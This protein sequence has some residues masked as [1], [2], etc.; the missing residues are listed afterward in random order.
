MCGKTAVAF[1]GQPRVAQRCV[2]TLSHLSTEAWECSAC[3][4]HTARS[5]RC[6]KQVQAKKPLFGPINIGIK[7]SCYKSSKW[8]NVCGDRV[9]SKYPLE[10]DLETLIPVGVFSLCFLKPFNCLFG[11]CLCSFSVLELS[12][13][14][15]GKAIN[16]CLFC[17][18]MTERSR[19]ILQVFLSPD[20][21]EK[22]KLYN[23]ST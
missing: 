17:H 8:R 7:A 23:T 6:C 21:G 13:V 14:I 3:C 19:M 20:C 9:L 11:S 18:V 16:S 22:K 12:L 4:S 10:D 15:P 2:R 5:D 1:L